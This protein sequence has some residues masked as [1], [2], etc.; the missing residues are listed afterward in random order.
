[1]SQ[2]AIR[3]AL[4]TVLA[5]MGAEGAPIQLERPRDSTHGDLASNVAMILAK[6]LGRPP[7]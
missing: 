3:A 4:G 1:M 7:R 2:E 5:G 6:K